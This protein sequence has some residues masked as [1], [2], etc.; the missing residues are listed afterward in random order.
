MIDNGCSCRRTRKEES[1][2]VMMGVWR[3]CSCLSVCLSACV[4]FERSGTVH[5]RNP[6]LSIR[7]MLFNNVADQSFNIFAMPF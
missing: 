5:D 4:W 7:S 1:V 2:I 6:Y 3:V